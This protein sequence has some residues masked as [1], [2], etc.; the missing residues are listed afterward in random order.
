M[1]LGDFNRLRDIAI[2]SFPLKQI[3]KH[4]T[5]RSSILDKIYT[6]VDKWYTQPVILPP[7]GNSDHNAVLFVPVP[8]ANVK[9]VITPRAYVYRSSDPNGKIFLAHDLKN[10]NWS[11][12]YSMNSCEQMLKYF[13]TVCHRHL[14]DRLPLLRG[15]KYP[16]D[17]PWVTNSFRTL[18]KRRQSA[19][20]TQNWSQ[21][22]FIATRLNVQLRHLNRNTIKDMSNFYAKPTH[23]NGGARSER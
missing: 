18:V 5:R 13:Y 3:V 9:H 22:D 23:T 6:N 21:Y 16:T 10:F 4:S 2:L 20:K 17:K 12:L 1:L 19:W 8:R 7:V 14:D 11:E 15:Y